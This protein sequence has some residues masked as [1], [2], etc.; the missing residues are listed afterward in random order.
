MIRIFLTGY[1]GAGKTTLGKAFARKLNL[2]F[3]DLDW[4][5]EERFHKTVGELFVER[6]EAGFR[7][8]EKNMLH[9]VGAFEDVVISTGGGAPCFFDNMDF[10]NRNGKTVFLNVHPD[11]LFRRL[12]VAKQQRPILQ[13]K[14]DDELKE[15]IIRAL[16][17]RTPFYSQAQ[18]V[19]N[20]DELEDRSQI[21]KSV[22]KLR[23][24]LKL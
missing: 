23:D 11:V 10:M 15:F 8:L 24:L 14:Q 5:M 12:R 20:A 21:E 4:Y 22:E 13:G 7:E 9:E 19:F 16:E 17:K 3:V 18:Y 6:G 1:M 2:P